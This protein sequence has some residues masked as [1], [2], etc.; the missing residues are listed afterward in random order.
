M[1]RSL[2]AGLALAAVTAL[3]ARAADLAVTVTE[4]GPAPGP[5]WVLVFA[6]DA[7]FPD[8]AA[9]TDRLRLD[10]ADTVT[11]RFNGLPPGRYAVMAYHDEDGDGDMDRFL[12]MIPQE[13]WGLSNGYDPSGKPDFAPAAVDLP[14][15]G[16]AITVPLRY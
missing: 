12:G 5:V 2:A 13:G 4:V 14:A 6:E 7:G 11:A 16:R 8:L 10:R 3:G 1:L 15:E 9:A